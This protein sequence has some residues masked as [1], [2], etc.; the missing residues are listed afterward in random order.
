MDKETKSCGKCVNESFCKGHIEI[1]DNG[2]DCLW[3]LK[4]ISKDND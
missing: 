1:K 2:F 4:P 3:F